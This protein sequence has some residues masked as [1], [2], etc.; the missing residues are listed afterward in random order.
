MV[1][2]TRPDRT[3]GPTQP[4][5]KGLPGLFPAVY[6][7]RGFDHQPH[8]VPSLK[9][10][11]NYTNTPLWAF[12]AWSRWTLL[13]F[14]ICFLVL[15][16]KIGPYQ[17]S[18]AKNLSTKWKFQPQGILY[19]SVFLCFSDLLNPQTHKQ[20]RL[21]KCKSEVHCWNQTLFV[22]V[23][24]SF[25]KLGHEFSFQIYS[26]QPAASMFCFTV[27]KHFLINDN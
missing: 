25:L 3:Y 19:E 5:V 21:T 22:T 8:L 7:E 13:L 4:P 1:F 11:Y 18:Y 12:M 17:T 14:L 2:L 27:L 9:K 6:P 15:V 26:S 16:H 20:T 23:L 24:H 10:E